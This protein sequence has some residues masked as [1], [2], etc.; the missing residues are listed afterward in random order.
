MIETYIGVWT[1][2]ERG[3]VNVLV[4]SCLGER[5]TCVC[6]GGGGGEGVGFRERVRC[7]YLRDFSVI[8]ICA[9]MVDQFVS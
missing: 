4:C 7:L 2:V 9:L 8:E 6:G 3:G 1:S 5:T